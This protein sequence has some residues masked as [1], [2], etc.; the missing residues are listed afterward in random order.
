VAEVKLLELEGTLD[1]TT[2]AM[3]NRIN[4]SSKNLMT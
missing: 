1:D 2:T 3:N 4:T